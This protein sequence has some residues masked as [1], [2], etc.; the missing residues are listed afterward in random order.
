VATRADGGAFDVEA[1]L[2]DPNRAFAAPEAVLDHAG[3]TREQKIEILRRWAS[4]ASALAVAEEEGMLGVDDDLL[5]RV[6]LALGRLTRG[7]D[8]RYVGPSKQHGLLRR[9]VEPEK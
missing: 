6:L 4:E 7:I 5:R 9:A 8:V 2:R 3:V 1:A